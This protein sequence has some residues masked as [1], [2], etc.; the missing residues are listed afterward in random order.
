MVNGPEMVGYEEVARKL[1]DKLGVEYK[2]VSVGK[3]E[4]IRR[5]VAMGKPEAVAGIMAWLEEYTA[6]GKEEQ[7]PTG[8]VEKLTGTKGVTL[9]EFIEKH[10]AEFGV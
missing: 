9:D 6:E 1:T 7:L 10:R 3:E 8:A 2:Y 4:L 5:H